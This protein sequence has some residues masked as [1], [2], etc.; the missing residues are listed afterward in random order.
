MPSVLHR[1]IFLLLA[2]ILLSSFAVS[3]SQNSLSTFVRDPASGREY[4]AYD[5]S[6]ALIVGIDAYTQVEARASSVASATSFKELLMSRF[7]FREENIVFLSN[8]QATQSAVM[9]AVR[10][11]Q[12]R[13]TQDRL[14]V[15]FSGRGCTSVDTLRRENGFFVPFDGQVQ[16]PSKTAATCISLGDVWRLISVAN[17]KQTLFL[18]DFTVGGLPR[19]FEVSGMPAPRLGFQRIVTLPS[20][21]ILAAGSRNESLTDDP[22][23]GLSCFTSKLIDALSSETT[24]VNTDGIITGTEL[25]ARTSVKVMEATQRKLHP[26]FG[27]MGADEGDFLFVLPRSADTSRI[28]FAIRPSDAA[29]FV[30]NK[31]VNPSD[32]GISVSSPTIGVHTLQVQHGGYRSFKG[33]FFVNGGVS[34]RA[35]ID[36]EQIPPTGL[37]VRVSEPDEK[38]S[39]D[40]N[41]VGMPDESL[42]I[43]HVGNGRHTVR[44]D[45]EGYYSDSVSITIDQPIQYAVSLK[46]VSRNG[47]LTVRTS[48]GVMIELNGQEI[49]TNNVVKKEV[50]P[51]AYVLRFSGIGYTTNE[52][53]VVVRDGESVEIDHPMSRPTLEGALLRSVVFPGWGQSYSGRHGIVYSAIF[54]VCAAA[55]VDLQFAYTKANSDY[56]SNV[57]N[58]G[59][60]QNQADSATFLKMATDSRNKRN[61][62]NNY[63]LAAFGVTGAFYLYSIINVWNNDPADLIREEEARSKRGLDVSL[64]IGQ[65]GPSLLM[66]FHF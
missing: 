21:E 35:N 9:D 33:D 34:I 61:N 4:H 7:G 5:E 3:Q 25:A 62:F 23:T 58:Y 12:H 48:E 26:Q 28:S 30:D 8:E 42:L 29:V 6:Y 2:V 1:N 22:A 54:V 18:M 39:L 47:F 20:R 36:L 16:S 38:V 59:A 64:G 19:D 43:Q 49:G 10:K 53:K 15:F 63:R 44:A 13:R 52:Q 50:L 45:L 56:A 60:A 27:S 31:K 41:F 46:L 11:F 24:D 14:L 57:H 37:L 65:D 17:A 32:R 55:S 51:G 40:G 66:S